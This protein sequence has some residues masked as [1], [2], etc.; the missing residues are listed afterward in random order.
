MEEQET[1]SKETKGKLRGNVILAKYIME[2]V[3]KKEEGTLV[4]YTWILQQFKMADM[5]DVVMCK[6]I[7]ALKKCIMIISDDM[8]IGA[9]LNFPWIRYDQSVAELYVDYIGD[10]ITAHPEYLQPVLHKLL[11]LVLSPEHQQSSV[12][13]NLHEGIKSVLYLTPKAPSQLIKVLERLAPYKGRK[14]TYQEVF[15]R[16]SLRIL[17][18]YPNLKQEILEL[19]ILKMLQIDVE[20]PSELEEEEDE[21]E[22]KMDKDNDDTQFPVDMDID[23]THLTASN[24]L[25][26]KDRCHPNSASTLLPHYSNHSNMKNPQAD[27]IDVIMTIMFEFIESV[28]YSDGKLNLEN[29]FDLFRILLKIFDE[30]IILTHGSSHVQFLIFK[31]TTF[32]ETFPSCFLDFLLEKFQDA[33]TAAVIRQAS[34]SYIASFIARSKFVSVNTAKLC[35]EVMNH[36]IHQYMSLVSKDKLRADVSK[37]GPFYSLCQA[38]FYVFVFRHKQI[39][40]TDGGRQ[41][42]LQLNFERLISS[43]LNPL[44]VCLQSIVEMFASVASKQEIVFCYTILEQ[45]KR[46]LLPTAV[47][48]TSSATI[49]QVSILETVFPFDPYHLKRSRKFI[50]DLYQ[51]WEGEEQEE[52]KTLLGTSLESHS[53]SSLLP[54]SMNSFVCSIT[55]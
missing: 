9:T 36:W 38:M 13:E 49:N 7:S 21:D 41:F 25:T 44:K 32:D 24:T 35:L 19:I 23:S 47:T 20:V 11:S 42:L 52:E 46:L 18:Y 45:N 3:R 8:I 30:Q 31:I 37:H 48:P 40:E 17:S 5:T 39:I 53:P 51:E 50:T 27:T 14:P 16:N 4:D 28:C 55:P 6:W 22:L 43:K 12:Y 29:T 26:D 10:L 2:S 54:S 33:N 1:Q 34:A 15:V